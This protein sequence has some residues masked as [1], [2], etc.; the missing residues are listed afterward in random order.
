MAAGLAL[1]AAC[2]GSEASRAGVISVTGG[3]FAQP[4]SVLHDSAAD[5][6]LV[7]NLRGSPLDKDGNGFISRV[8]PDGK[9]LAPRWIEGGRGGAVL[10]APKGTGIR[11]DTLY[12][13]DID[14]VRR[15]HRTTGAPLGEIPI[16]GATFLNDVAVGADGSVYVTDM[17]LRMGAGRMQASGTAAIHRIAPGGQVRTLASGPEL[18]SPNGIV[19]DADGTVTVAGYTSG[20]VLRIAPGGART[21]LQAPSRGQLDGLVRTRDGTLLVSDWKRSAVYAVRADAGPA[22]AVRDLPSPA[23][24]GYDARRHRLLVPLMTVSRVELH[25]L[26]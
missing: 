17:G 5:V 18:G 10:N 6:Y 8:S 24:I 19:V 26:P 15:F 9:V 20:D 2:G 12:V 14:V 11:G 13:A 22:V 1:L 21:P 16:Q 4:E 7:S 25:P 23:D 3:E